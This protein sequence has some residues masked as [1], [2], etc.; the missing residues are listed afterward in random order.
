MV[1]I[2]SPIRWIKS[3][4]NNKLS[5]EKGCRVRQW[6]IFSG[7]TLEGDTGEAWI[8]TWGI[9]FNRKLK[10]IILVLIKA[11]GRAREKRNTKRKTRQKEQ[12]SPCVLKELKYW[13][14]VSLQLRGLK[15][16]QADSAGSDLGEWFALKRFLGGSNG[17]RGWGAAELLF[18]PQ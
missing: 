14:I 5:N 13:F 2:S 17:S 6:S 15:K 11:D 12:E 1:I 7:D 16:S 18:Q 10:I 9:L 4:Q 8:N 3:C